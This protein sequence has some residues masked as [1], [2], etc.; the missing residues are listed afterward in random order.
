MKRPVI[1]ADTGS[2]DWQDYAEFLEKEVE[3]YRKALEYYTEAL[4]DMGF[5]DGMT[6]RAALVSND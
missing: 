2:D 6:A 5:D 4:T 3:R 1:D